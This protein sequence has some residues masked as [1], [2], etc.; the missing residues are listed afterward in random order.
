MKRKP[1]ANEFSHFFGKYIFWKHFTVL[2]TIKTLNFSFKKKLVLAKK[3]YLRANIP[4]HNKAYYGFW[5]GILN[6]FPNLFIELQCIQCLG[7]ICKLQ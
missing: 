5:Y 2:V 3:L 1:I 4:R 6:P 7:L